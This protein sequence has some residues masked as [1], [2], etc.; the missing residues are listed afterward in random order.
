M[1]LNFKK[2]LHFDLKS[3][4]DLATDF[5][6]PFFQK[7]E[8][9][10]Q[11]GLVGISFSE[12]K[13][14][15]A[16]LFSEDDRIKVVL[17]AS[18]VANNLEDRAKA[19]KDI[20]K[21]YN[22]EK[23]LCSIVIPP[24]SYKLTM[25][26]KPN[27]PEEELK[28]GVETLIQD[29]LDESVEEYS[30]DFISIPFT[31]SSD[32][33]KV[34]LVAS[35]PIDYMKEIEKAVIDAELEVEAIDIP[36]MCYRNLSSLDKEAIQGYMIVNLDRKGCYLY[37][38]NNDNLIMS[39][40]INANLSKFL[41]NGNGDSYLNPEVEDQDLENLALQIQ[42][43]IDYCNSIFREAPIDKLIFFPSEV[44]IEVVSSYLSNHIGL[45]T[46][47]SDLPSLVDMPENYEIETYGEFLPAIGAALRGIRFKADAT[48]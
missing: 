17:M 24:G 40:R 19:L 6:L 13:L 4:K 42:R 9:I 14:H 10:E 43:T 27:T 5:K 15:V 22:L 29:Y 36:E 2:L 8:E 3:L 37:I 31:R 25:I 23:Q 12:H 28:S 38:Y 35:I 47:I 48:N 30:I 11:V 39:R 32:N 44:K 18:K 16:Y 26:E 1:D 7:E 33:K 20:V 46:H 41:N 34:L 45:K 21:E